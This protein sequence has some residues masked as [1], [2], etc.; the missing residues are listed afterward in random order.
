MDSFKCKYPLA[1]VLEEGL[2]KWRDH[3]LVETKKT[4][5]GQSLIPGSLILTHIRVHQDAS[6]RSTWRTV[7]ESSSL[8]T[9]RASIRRARNATGGSGPAATSA[10]SSSSPTSSSTSPA[11]TFSPSENQVRRSPVRLSP[12]FLVNNYR[13][14]TAWAVWHRESVHATG[15]PGFESGSSQSNHVPMTFSGLD[16]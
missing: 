16:C 7:S 10:S 14:V 2:L 6:A 11:A 15:C 9:F 1:L 4:L 12:I 5:L 13:R 8:R 3:N